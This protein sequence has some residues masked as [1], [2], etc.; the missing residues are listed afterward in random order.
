MLEASAASDWY[1]ARDAKV[2]EDFRIALDETVEQVAALPGV[3]SPWPGEPGVRPCTPSKLPLLGGLRGKRGRDHHPRGGPREAEADLLA[4]AVN[5]SAGVGPLEDIGLAGAQLL[6][7]T[8]N[9]GRPGCLDVA[10]GVEA[11]ENLTEQLDALALRERK[12]LGEEGL[13]VL[14]HGPM[15]TGAPSSEPQEAGSQFPP[16]GGEPEPPTERDPLKSGVGSRSWGLA[17]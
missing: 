5:R 6:E 8:A 13:K 10:G 17:W 16:H 11:L 9:L 2:A 4:G 15:V 14:G 7:P 3:G 12:N 1:A